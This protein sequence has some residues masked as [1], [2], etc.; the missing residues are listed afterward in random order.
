MDNSSDSDDVVPVAITEAVD[1]AV[2]VIKIEDCK[3][4]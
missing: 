3:K 1:A 4:V 2:N